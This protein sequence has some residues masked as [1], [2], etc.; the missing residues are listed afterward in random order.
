M[1]KSRKDYNYF[2][3]TVKV[4]ATN[5]DHKVIDEIIYDNVIKVS[6]DTDFNGDY[7]R[8][9]TKDENEATFH[10]EYGFYWEVIKSDKRVR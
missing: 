10:V 8:I 3:A 4:I 2:Y 5:E 6:C 1:T 7:F 9:Y